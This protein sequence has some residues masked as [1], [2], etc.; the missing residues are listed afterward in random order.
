MNIARK[1]SIEIREGMIP[2]MNG[3]RSS[4]T[5]LLETGQSS[6]AQTLDCT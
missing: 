5:N 4:F 2:F 3:G 6:R 1:Q